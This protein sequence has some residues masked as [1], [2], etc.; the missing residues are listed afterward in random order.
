MQES[1]IVVELLEQFWNQVFTGGS[2]ENGHS[3][4]DSE[5][6]EGMFSMLI[7]VQ[8]AYTESVNSLKAG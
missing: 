1:E 7:S 4:P 8:W 2:G 5:W 3:C 6:T